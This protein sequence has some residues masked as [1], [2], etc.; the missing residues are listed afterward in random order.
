GRDTSGVA[1]IV[2]TAYRHEPAGV[3]VRVTRPQFGV[4]APVSGI[5]HY[6]G[7]PPGDVMVGAGDSLDALSY[8]GAGAPIENVTADIVSSNPSIASLDSTSLTIP[9]GQGPS[10]AAHLSFNAPGNVTITAK[11]PSFAYYHYGT[12]T[13]AT[14]RLV[15]KRLVFTHSVML[16]GIGQFSP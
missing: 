7:E 9:A 6:P 11:D 4:G 8:S 13:S 16:L 5:P 14:V 1:S 3:T 2:V 15:P 10:G 12:G